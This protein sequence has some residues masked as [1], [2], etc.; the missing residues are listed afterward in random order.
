MSEIESTEATRD[1]AETSEQGEKGAVVDGPK[2]VDEI[3]RAARKAQPAW[4]AKP[5]EERASAVDKARLRLLQRAEAIAG[6]IAEETGKPT[7]EALLGE[8]LASSD[9]F[10]HWGQVLE[11][12]VE[13]R[14]L[15]LDPISYPGKEA[16]IHSAARGVVAY[17]RASRRIVAASIP[18]AA[19]T[20]SGENG[21]TSARTSS[22]PSVNAANR[23]SAT[24]PSS[25]NTWHIAARKNASL[26]GLM[27]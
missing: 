15:S 4:E 10:T 8:V 21:C 27:P 11:E 12:E 25:K 23:P 5:L 17:S 26:P 24:S 7:V 19:A 18:V 14:E 2:G 20:A 22:T 3:L 9:V 16:F 13:P 6:V 1:E